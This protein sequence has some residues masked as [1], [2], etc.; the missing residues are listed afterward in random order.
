MVVSLNESK[1][2]DIIFSSV[3]LSSIDVASSKIRPA[4]KSQAEISEPVSEGKKA[5]QTKPLRIT[6]FRWWLA[7]M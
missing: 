7:N 1:R 4:N 6:N 5:H 2:I 3:S